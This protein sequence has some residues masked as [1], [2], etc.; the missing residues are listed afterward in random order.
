MIRRSTRY[1]LSLCLVAA[2]FLLAVFSVSVHAEEAQEE[3]PQTP[4]LTLVSDVKEALRGKKLRITASWHSIGDRRSLSAF[5]LQL[6]YDENYLTLTDIEPAD[7]MN[8]G[9]FRSNLTEAGAI[10]V[11]ASAKHAIPLADG[12]CCTFVFT[13][14]EDAAVCSADVTVS[15]DQLVTPDLEKLTNKDS[16]TISV[17]MARIL[18]GDALLESLVPSAGELT[19]NFSPEITEYTLQVPYEVTQ[20]TFDAKPKDNAT[21]RVNRKN[22]G[23]AGMP[24]TFILTVT[25]E[26][27]EAKTEYVVTATRGQKSTAGSTGSKSTSGKKTSSSSGKSG[28]T[29]AKE[30]ILGTGNGNG[31]ITQYGN[32]IIYYNENTYSVFIIGALCVG[33]CALA[34]ALVLFARRRGRPAEKGNDP[35]SHTKKK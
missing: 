26:N 30:G 33:I 2:F 29:T 20:L 34:I 23:A 16:D 13:V 17:P 27:G 21:V 28:G 25:S 19:P 3:T 35:S 8:T 4:S 18:S 1:C 15:A 5:R 12:T 7:T 10:F 14:H 31:G 9:D 6:S 11:Y 22:L 24:I 32:R